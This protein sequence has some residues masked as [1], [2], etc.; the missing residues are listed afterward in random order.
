M[1]RE[2]FLLLMLEQTVLLINIL[3]KFGSIGLYQI[4]TQRYVPC[5]FSQ[6]PDFGILT[7]IFLLDDHK[8]LGFQLFFLF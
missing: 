8:F 7:V 3:Y 6:L 1:L 2:G 5:L 4:I